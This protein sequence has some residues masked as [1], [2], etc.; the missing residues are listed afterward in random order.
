MRRQ[1][2]HINRT[3]FNVFT[4]FPPEVVVTCRKL[5]TE[6]KTERVK[7][8]RSWIAYDTLYVDGRPVR[9]KG[10]EGGEI[11]IFRAMFMVL[12]IARKVI[13]PL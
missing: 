9:I 6:L 8:K 10:H 3:G 13:L 4:Q 1:W 7:G 2:K 12:Q 11:D 5:I